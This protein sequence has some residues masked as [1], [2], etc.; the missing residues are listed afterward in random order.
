MLLYV[1]RDADSFE[2]QIAENF[3]SDARAV[4][5]AVRARQRARTKDALALMIAAHAAQAMRLAIS[6]ADGL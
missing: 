2:Q 5:T 6:A 1:G 3:G 4:S